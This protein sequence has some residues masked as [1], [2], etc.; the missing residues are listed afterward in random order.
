MVCPCQCMLLGQCGKSLRLR[1]TR[2]LLREEALEGV[3][4]DV[5]RPPGR[6]DLTLLLNTSLCLDQKGIRRQ[7]SL[8]T[9]SLCAS[10]KPSPGRP[11]FPGCLEGVEQW[12][13]KVSFWLKH[14]VHFGSTP[15]PGGPQCRVCGQAVQWVRC[16]A[17]QR[18]PP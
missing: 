15:C 8:C 13:L 3:G 7:P 14:S 1:P 16:G 9:I 6:L 10:D 11:R 2:P 4:Y 17:M 18:F 5:A 12:H